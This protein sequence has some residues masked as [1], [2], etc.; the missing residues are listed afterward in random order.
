[1]WKGP[2]GQASRPKESTS[3]PGVCLSRP[4]MRYCLH[5]AVGNFHCT[6]MSLIIPPRSMLFPNDMLGSDC[7]LSMFILRWVVGV[8]PRV[9]TCLR[10]RWR[11]GIRRFD[12]KWCQVWFSSLKVRLELSFR[13][14]RVLR[15]NGIQAELQQSTAWVQRSASSRCH[16][17][18]CGT[19]T[20]LIPYPW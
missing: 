15:R 18:S 2:A 16:N 10:P 5:K 4:V 1:M 19:W 9:L 11:N 20:N 17:A 6:T 3:F 14:S 12:L 7:L 13:R 8:S